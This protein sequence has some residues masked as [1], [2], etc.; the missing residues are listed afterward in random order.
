M[1]MNKRIHN[2]AE[3][4]RTV[5]KRFDNADLEW[6]STCDFAAFIY[7]GA[8]LGL[9]TWRDLPSDLQH[10]IFEKLESEPIHSCRLLSV[11]FFG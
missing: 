3:L 1:K 6:T 8:K 5:L 10:T 4:E 9:V 2:C 11:L 7:F